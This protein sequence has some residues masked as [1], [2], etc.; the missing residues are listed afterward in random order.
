[1]TRRAIRIKHTVAGYHR[2]RMQ[3][4]DPIQRAQPLA[5]GLFIALREIGVIVS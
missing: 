2:S 3:S 5:P 4:L 1:V